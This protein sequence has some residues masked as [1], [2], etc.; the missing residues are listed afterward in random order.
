MKISKEVLR[1]PPGTRPGGTSENS[2]AFQRWVGTQWGKS[3]EGTSDLAALQPSLRD[4][5]R[6][7][8]C[9]SAETL[10]FSRPSLRDERV[11]NPSGIGFSTCGSFVIVSPT[12]PEPTRIR[13]T[14][15]F[16]SA[17]QQIENLRYGTRQVRLF[18]GLRFAAL[19][20]LA[21]AI[22]LAS[23]SAPLT[24]TNGPVKVEVR[25]TDGRYQLY[26]DGK[27]FYV[28]GA[29]LEFGNQEKLAA[30]GGNSFRTWRTEN[31]Q[32]SC[33]QVLD[34]AM[35]NGLYVTMGLDVARERH[36]FNYNDPAAVAKQFEKIKAEVLKYK[37]HP[38]LLMWAIGNELNL[39]ANN[40]KVWDAVNDLSKMIHQVDPNH[41]TTSPLAGI[42][43]DLV[44][45]LKTHAPDLDV[46]SVQMYADIVNLPRYLKEA[47]WTGPYL[48]TEW[49]ATGHWEVGKTD[50]GAPL[51]NDST[52]KADF[53]KKRYE[54]VIQADPRQ[55]VGSYV[56]LWGQKQERTPTWYGMFLE[57]GEETATVDVL[58]YF[59]S[60]AWPANRSPRLE[61]AWLDG[62]T[63][64]QSIHLKP[65]QAYP[66]KVLASDPDQDPLRYTWEVM[67][68][69]TDL[70]WGGDSE[71]KPKTLRECIAAPDR[72]EIV[73]K[74]PA[75][76][77][78]YRL[79]AYVFDGKG[80][81]AHVNIPFYVDGASGTSARV[82]EH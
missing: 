59:W 2:P 9:P 76:P 21:A 14:A 20:C 27:P 36:G 43:R 23:Q 49:G 39:G 67:E 47:G 81:A 6:P 16:K 29:G 52:T 77:G 1:D 73:V 4:L 55:C 5:T 31:G 82:A 26:V 32:A 57:T 17:I 38:A 40:P 28:K 62:K 72:S 34:R 42:N 25:Q 30:H 66:A 41:L 35:Q 12:K 24:K 78:A 65:G 50:W 74:T 69:S 7:Y 45:Q 11:Q 80:H 46:L 53:Y 54:T 13:T 51:E 68:E 64:K 60:G 19:L 10:A 70:K 3:P 63:A 48:V 22:P 15:D 18:A 75:K 58:H 56:F 71:S 37:D 61:G 33:Q 79:F 8:D 44:E